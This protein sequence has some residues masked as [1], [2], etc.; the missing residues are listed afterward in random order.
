MIQKTQI[1]HRLVGISYIKNPKNKLQVNHIKGGKTD[2]RVSRLEWATNLENH[3]HAIKMGLKDNKGEKGGKATLS[4]KQV[5]EIFN[6]N[7]TSS[8]LSKEYN[9]NIFNINLI[10]SGKNWSSVTGKK[11]QRK[12][13]TKQKIIDVF[14]SE[15]SIRLTSRKF[16]ISENVVR[17]IKNGFTWSSVTGKKYIKTKR[18]SDLEME[19]IV[20][21][22]LRPKEIAKIYNLSSRTVYNIRYNRKKMSA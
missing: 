10:K 6:S 20:G 18:L 7:L 16:S 9:T 12:F 4:N 5:L 17:N 1:V 8:E 22:N 2:N 21:S 14:N 3:N 13:I 15:L 11:Y 19:Q